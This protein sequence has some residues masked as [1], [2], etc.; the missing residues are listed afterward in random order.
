M[1]ELIVYDI[2]WQS[3]FI[4][5]NEMKYFRWMKSKTLFAKLDLMHSNKAASYV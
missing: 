4:Q 2:C 3:G 5:V 1:I